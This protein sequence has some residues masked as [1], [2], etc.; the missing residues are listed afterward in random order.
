MIRKTYSIPSMHCT[1]CVMTLE[2]L[3]DELPGIE[4]IQASYQKQKLVIEFDESQVSE[5][6]IRQAIAALDHRIA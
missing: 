2:A 1:S 5:A 6:E 4:F 3:E